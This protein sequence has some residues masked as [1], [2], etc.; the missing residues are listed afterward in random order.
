[1]TPEIDAKRLELLKELAPDASR[2]AVL[3]NPVNPNNRAR[4]PTMQA[5]AKSLRLTLERLGAGDSEQLDRASRPS[6][7]R[8][9][10]R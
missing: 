1:M 8:V 10:R 3:W 4:I 2:V 9:L 6:S 7:R 5:A